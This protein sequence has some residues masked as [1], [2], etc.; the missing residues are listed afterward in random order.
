MQDKKGEWFNLKYDLAELIIP[1]LEQYKTGYLKEGMSI[2]SWL[3]SEKKESYSDI[4]IEELS[5]RW[6]MEIDKMIYGFKGVLDYKLNYNIDY[7]E[8][9]IQEG[10]NI[11]AKHFQDFWD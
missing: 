4:E 6:I 9:K 7:D 5:K 8:D 1:K 11:F 2:P 3:L 10:L